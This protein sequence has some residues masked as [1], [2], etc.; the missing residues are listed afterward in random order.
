[1]LQ[2]IVDLV[3]CIQR[4]SLTLNNAYLQILAEPAR[5]QDCTF[6]CFK[7]VWLTRVISEIRMQHQTRFHLTGIYI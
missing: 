3:V 7:Y 1:M 4:H 2:R 5:Y 6:Q